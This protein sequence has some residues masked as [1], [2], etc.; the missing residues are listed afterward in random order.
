MSKLLIP[1]DFSEYSNNATH[2][3]C[4]IAKE[5]GQEIDLIH[6]F[7]S[8]SNSLANVTGESP[9]HDPRVPE[10]EESMNNTITKFQDEFPG[11]KLNS[12]FRNGNLYDE[13]KAVTSATDYDA[14][15]MGTHGASGLESV[16]IGSNTYDTI[17]NTKTPVLAIPASSTNYKKDHI[18]LLCNFKEAEL[19]A[20]QQ[21]IPLFKNDFRL[22]L[23]H[24]NTN[25]KSVAEVDLNFKD[26]INRIESELGIS[27]IS[28]IIKPQTLF[29]RQKEPVAQAIN[30]VLI[31]EQ[32]DILILTKSKK[33]VFRKLTESNVIKKMAF[34]IKIPTFF[35][36]VLIG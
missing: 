11:I 4:Q 2:Y 34:N 16:F 29:M 14:V 1:I 27:D 5:S 12:I 18:A 10:A 36:R 17:L 33:S 35:A 22:I 28:Y 25:E 30:S 15:V 13:I 8:H 6:V 20:L 21:A 31:D 26:W 3:A 19:S 9:L 23:I 24:V 32:V 7:S